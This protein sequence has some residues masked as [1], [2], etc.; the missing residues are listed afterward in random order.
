MKIFARIQDRQPCCLDGILSLYQVRVAAP[1]I[2]ALRLRRSD[3]S[4]ER[5]GAGLATANGSRPDGGH[6]PPPSAHAVRLFAAIAANKLRCF[7]G[8]GAASLCLAA[9]RRIVPRANRTAVMQMPGLLRWSARYLREAR[10]GGR[11]APPC[12]VRAAAAYGG[13]RPLRPSP[14]GVVPASSGCLPAPRRRWRLDGGVASCGPRRRAWGLPRALF[15]AAPP[16]PGGP[17][18]AAPPPL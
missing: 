18:A 10:R 11:A 15:S 9:G 16:A 17:G 12:P 3:G 8:L 5:C 2:A 7:G 1:E 13:R 6:G 4:A 14:P